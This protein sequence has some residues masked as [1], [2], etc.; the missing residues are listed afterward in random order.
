M[1][2]NIVVPV[3]HSVQSENAVKFYLKSIH[4]HGNR[5]VLVRCIELPEPSINKARDSHVSPAIL[6][7]L[8]KEEQAKNKGLEEKMTALL[9]QQKVPGILRTTVGKPGEVICRV[10]EEEN[11]IL[12]ITAAQPMSRVR[13]TLLGDVT[14]FLMSHAACPVVVCGDPVEVE[15]RRRQ[16]SSSGAGTSRKMRHFSGDSIHVFTSRIRHRFA[17]GS[18]CLSGSRT[19]DHDALFGDGKEI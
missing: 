6:T 10:A 9:K 8:W 12:I 19:S 2:Q 18:K 15:R 14:D 7:N 5:L 4:R 13:R 1:Q 17:S 11:A 16:A 3:D